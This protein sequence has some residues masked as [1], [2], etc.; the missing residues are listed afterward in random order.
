MRNYFRVYLL[1]ILVASNI[2]VFANT[3]ITGTLKLDQNWQK[4]VY[5]SKL[6]NFNCILSGSNACVVDSQIISK[7]GT[8]SFND[9]TANTAYRISVIPK[10]P[11]GM[12]GGSIIQNGKDDNYAFFI[13]GNDNSIITLNANI[14]NLFLSYN[15]KTSIPKLAAVNNRVLKIRT[16][17][18]PVYHFMAS[19]RAKF[20]LNGNN[21]NLD[22]QSI[23]QDYLK[24]I[25][26]FVQTSNSG[27]DSIMLSETDKNVFS[28]ALAF[29]GLDFASI[30]Q[31]QQLLNY[32]KDAFDNNNLQLLFTSSVEKLSQ[33]L[34]PVSP[35]FLM[36]TYKTIDDEPFSFMN[37]MNSTDFIL[38]DFWASWC[39][40][41]RKSIKTD[42]V[43]LRKTYNNNLLTIIGVNN[44][45]D[46][47]QAESAIL[48]DN[49]INLQLYDYPELKLNKRFKI[50]AIPYYAIINLR[51]QTIS[52]F[53]HIFQVQEYLLNNIK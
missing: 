11:E 30:E 9:L 40:P 48:K 1:L 34:T 32:S 6:N 26:V 44:D 8:F 25:Q 10:V 47:Q 19:Q 39:V 37:L 20:Q 31:K 53:Q 18:L 4:K 35:L 36:G 7:D 17:M 46:K 15:L 49:N 42:L 22:M 12:S 3:K 21:E 50:E 28:I 38:L 27:L 2:N 14:T 45:E 16:E 52:V 33:S 23:Q 5:L 43:D 51:D 24:Q 13:T 41:C 29:Y